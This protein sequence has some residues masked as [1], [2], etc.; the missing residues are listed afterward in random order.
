MVVGRNLGDDLASG[1]VRTQACRRLPPLEAAQIVVD[2]CRGADLTLFTPKGSLVQTKQ[3]PP[4]PRVLD[5]TGKIRNMRGMI[6]GKA[7]E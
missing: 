1:P 7:S 3:S 4:A 6:S 2:A 5:E